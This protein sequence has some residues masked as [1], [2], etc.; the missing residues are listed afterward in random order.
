MINMGQIKILLTNISYPY[1]NYGVQGILLPFIEKLSRHF[2]AEYGLIIKKKFYKENVD[3]CRKHNIHAVKSLPA[4]A[5]LARDNLL[6][7]SFFNLYRWLKKKRIVNSDKYT[8]FFNE[9]KKYDVIINLC[10]IQFIGNKSI[11]RKYAEYYTS[12]YPK[13]LSKK[14]GK[15]YLEYTKSYGPF[16]GK[17]YRF[18]TKKHL[19]SIPFIFVRGKNNL[20][21]VRK[22]KLQKPT[23]SFPDISL[24]LEPAEKGWASSYLKTLGL[25][26]SKKIVGVSPSSVIY[27]LTTKEKTSKGK[28]H[29][30]LCEKIINFYAKENNQVI[31]LPH[32]IEY[33]M[34]DAN[35]ADLTLSKRLFKRIKNK[36]RV[37]LIADKGLTYRQTRAIIG[38]MDFYVTGRYHSVSSALFEGTPVVA[39]SWHIKYRD[40]LSLFLSKD[41]PTINC[42]KTNIEDA[43]A[44]VEKYYYD[45]SW[46]DKKKILEKQN[47]IIRKIDCSIEILSNA[48]ENNN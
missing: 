37:F 36:E 16:V 30:Y 22:L 3:F 43:M 24:S 42:R 47:D 23:Y 8:N 2:D 25:D 5:L 45:R 33:D 34:S 44:L 21:E 40:I 6:L 14:F 41:I 12:I 7:K 11:I 46:F 4:G 31:I 32:S 26:C 27:N 18:L 17:F 9:V 39:L 48:I 38:M 28:N 15:L 29:F 1:R 10:G 19:N 35:V 20:E 13:W